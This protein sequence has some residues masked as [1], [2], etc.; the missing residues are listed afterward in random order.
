[1]SSHPAKIGAMSSE[2]AQPSRYGHLASV[3]A[4]QIRRGDY[5][6]GDELPPIATIAADFGVSHMTAKEALR[7][8][9]DQD[10][11]QTGRGVRARVVAIPD[12]APFTLPEQLDLIRGRLHQLELRASA[13][14]QHA[15]K[16][17]GH[18]PA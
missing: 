9:R 8:L 15:S 4:T 6:I 10:A 11:V 5:A 18:D 14:E 2:P 17:T 3:L 1:M 12:E 16:P 7:V 13:L